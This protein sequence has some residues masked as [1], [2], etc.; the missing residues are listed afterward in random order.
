M[1]D[2]RINYAEVSAEVC[3]SAESVCEGRGRPV[4]SVIVVLMMS[5]KMTLL[6]MSPTWQQTKMYPEAFTAW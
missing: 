2:E 5:E 1:T 6:S 3:R 4:L